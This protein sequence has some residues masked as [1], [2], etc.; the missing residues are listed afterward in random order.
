MPLL[1]VVVRP[2][3]AGRS[4]FIA[5]LAVVLKD[6]KHVNPAP[7]YFRVGIGLAHAKALHEPQRIFI[8][9]F[10]DPFTLCIQVIFFILF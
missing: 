5:Q 10:P 9:P 7:G 1:K 4:V 2:C 8:P 3:T 6:A